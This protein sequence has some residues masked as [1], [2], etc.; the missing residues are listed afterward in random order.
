MPKY[1]R[2]AASRSSEHVTKSGGI[3]KSNCV[4]NVIM[5]Q[6]RGY[7]RRAGEGL[8]LR[9]VLYLFGAC[10]DLNFSALKE[11]GRRVAVVFE[12]H[13]AHA[14]GERFYDEPDEF[15]RRRFNI[16]PAYANV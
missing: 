2:G 12:L 1:A 16:E 5:W 4:G 8:I 7:R 10:K 3:T 11:A 14:R 15:G 6:A 13:S 9:D